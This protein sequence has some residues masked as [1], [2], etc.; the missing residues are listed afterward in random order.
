MAPQIVAL[1]NLSNGRF[2]MGAGLGLDRSGQEL[3]AFGE[4]LHDRTRADM[5]DESLDLL[6]KLMSGE[7][8]T[9]EGQHYVA[10][11]VKF[12]PRPVRGTVPIWMAARWRH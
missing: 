1:D 3:S 9:H 6:Q 5:L 7:R 12:L 4:E 11:D 8:F 2:I 10:D